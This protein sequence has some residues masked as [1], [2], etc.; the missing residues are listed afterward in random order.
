MKENPICGIGDK[1][2]SAIL[3]N[4]KGICVDIT[5]S[6]RH[7]EY[8]YVVSFGIDP[9]EEVKLKECELSL[10]PVFSV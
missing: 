7:K 9:N 4:K 8:S 10:T 5:Y 2:Y 3:E 1:V 6:I